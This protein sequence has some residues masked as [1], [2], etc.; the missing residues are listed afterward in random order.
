MWLAQRKKRPKY[1]NKAESFDPGE[2]NIIRENV[3]VIGEVSYF[4]VLPILLTPDPSTFRLK[5]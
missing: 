4:F 5:A 2:I 3:T 1:K